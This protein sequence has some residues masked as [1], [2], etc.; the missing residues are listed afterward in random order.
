M[1]CANISHSNWQR[2]F[3]FTFVQEKQGRFSPLTENVRNKRRLVPDI[4][5]I[6]FWLDLRQAVGFSSWFPGIVKKL[7]RPLP[8][9]SLSIG[10]ITN[11]DSVLYLLIDNRGMDW[12]CPAWE[13]YVR[14]FAT[15]D[16]KVSADKYFLMLLN[17]F[18][19]SMLLRPDET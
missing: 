16:G 4:V 8:L 2:Q 7:S 13:L 1:Q 3:A 5:I 12:Y 14:D 6:S 11:I 19:F 18:P 15:L 17:L 10:K 9:L